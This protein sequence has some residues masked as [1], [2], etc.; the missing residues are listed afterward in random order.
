MLSNL[1]EAFV[2]KSEKREKSKKRIHWCYIEDTYAHTYTY[3]YTVY[4]SHTHLMQTRRPHALVCLS[5]RNTN[6][7][8]TI[9]SW[10]KNILFVSEQFVR[11]CWNSAA[12]TF[13]V[14]MLDSWSI[15]PPNG[16]ITDNRNFIATNRWHG[17]QQHLTPTAHTAY[18]MSWQH[19]IR[20][21]KKCLF[22]SF[23][24]SKKKL[25]SIL[26]TMSIFNSIL[27]DFY[28]KKKGICSKPPTQ[29]IHSM[30]NLITWSQLNINWVIIWLR[31]FFSFIGIYWLWW[32]VV[33]KQGRNRTRHAKA[34]YV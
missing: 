4:I 24:C 21:Q 13:N 28:L 18:Y 27:S 29:D 34:K 20:M 5:K 3:M 31:W 6:T 22:L 8:K 33:L 17:I 14:S 11:I 2:W 10:N 25:H 9:D 32:R 26:A 19:A 15:H 23:F 30:L 7:K 1:T 16:I 12:T